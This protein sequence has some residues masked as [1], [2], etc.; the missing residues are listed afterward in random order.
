MLISVVIRTYNEEKY[1]R[2]GRWV[3]RTELPSEFLGVDLVMCELG[4]SNEG[5]I[6]ERK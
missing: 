1:L 5:A 6:D 2:F 3:N 4:L